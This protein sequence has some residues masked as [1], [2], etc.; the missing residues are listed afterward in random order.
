MEAVLRKKLQLNSIILKKAL[1]SSNNNKG[2]SIIEVITSMLILMLVSLPVFMLFTSSAAIIR[3]T[4]KQIEINAVIKVVK[5]NVTNS[6]TMDTYQLEY[7]IGGSFVN[8]KQG[9]LDNAVTNPIT[10]YDNIII[11]DSKTIPNSK[12]IYKLDILN[13]PI[14][15][16]SVISGYDNTCVC[17]ITLK[18]INGDLVQKLK[19]E[20]NIGNLATNLQPY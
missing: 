18:K 16:L 17:L 12:Y 6:L 3:L 8:L 20:V 11:K 10:T 4:E 1:A 15:T 13:G 9:V 14:N 19:I 5:E 7:N 2:I